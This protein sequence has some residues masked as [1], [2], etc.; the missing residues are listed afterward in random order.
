LTNG[1]T[2]PDGT[3]IFQICFDAI[4][5]EGVYPIGFSN[6]PTSIEIIDALTTTVI[7]PVNLVGGEVEIEDLIIGTD[8]FTLDIS[9]E[10][11][12]SGENVCVDVTA[13]NFDN[14]LAMQFSIDYDETA[15]TYTGIEGVNLVDLTAA[16]FGNPTPGV[17]TL[18]WTSNSDLVNGATVPDG[19]TIFQICFDAIG[20]D[21]VYPVEF[22]NTP[23]SIEIIDALTTTIINPVNL[24]NGEVEIG[25]DNDDATITLTASEHVVPQGDP[26]CVSISS[27][28]FEQLVNLSFEVEYDEDILVFDQVDNIQL[29]GLT[30]SD[31]TDNV[32]DILVSWSSATPIDFTGGVLFDLC[33]TT[34]GAVGD[35]SDMDF[36]DATA[37]D[38]EGVVEVETE[39]GYVQIDSDIDG[40]ALI[41]SDACVAPGE[42]FCMAWGD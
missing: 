30:A 19:T 15:L 17:V 12:L 6:T 1:A 20:S 8:D 27:T 4:G 7:D 24:V 9:E 31:I 39:D 23:T 14:I 22:S 41:F 38:S 33:F 16:N 2:V 3:T 25:E 21:G 29:P 36:D 18:S 11:T 35:I 34:I 26:V 5:S 37:T 40:F 10:T 32:G 28:A 13:S 42:N